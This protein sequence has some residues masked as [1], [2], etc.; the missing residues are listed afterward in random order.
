MSAKMGN[1]VPLALSET[2]PTSDAASLEMEAAVRE[3]ARL[4]YKIS[5]S[6]LG[7]H[8]DAEDA[9]QET[10]FRYFRHRSDWR[11]IRD[12]R[13]WLARVAWRVALDHRRAAPEIPLGEAAEAVGEFKATGAGPEEIASRREMQALLGQLIE[14]LPKE[15]REAV[16]LSS[17]EDLSSR[18]VGE[19]LG[20]PEGSVRERLWRARKILKEKLE[21]ILG[22]SHGR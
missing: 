12:R 13:A 4:V 19:I 17:A 15:L 18:E 20:I 11:E 16:W 2:M 6:V 21:R 9:A 1:P 5:Y 8:H 10:F 14:T 7:N 22:G 3:S